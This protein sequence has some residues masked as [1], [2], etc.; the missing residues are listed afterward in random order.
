[1]YLDRYAEA[2]AKAGFAVVVFDYRNFGA[3][4]GEPRQEINPWDQVEDY[5]NAITYATTL[6]GIDAS[7]IGVWGS[8]YSGAHALTVAATDRRVKCVVSQV[9]TVSGH[10]NGIRRVPMERVPALTAM[11]TEDRKRRMRGEAPAMRVVIGPPEAGPL[12]PHDDARE[13]FTEASKFAPSWRNEVTLRS[14]EWSRAYEPGAHISHISP[15]PLLMIIATHD[16][17]TATDLELEAY[18][19]A[20]EPKKL[21]LFEGG[22]F[23]GYVHKF[24]ETSEP[25]VEW[26]VTHLKP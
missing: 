23:D 9:P 14:A 15:T 8:S 22:H 20:L 10:D 7:R 26:F 3:S 4:E 18:N 24:A 1:M 6:D 19:R 2:F 21:V 5:R 13:W 11:L 17:T 25:A 16:V 12:Y